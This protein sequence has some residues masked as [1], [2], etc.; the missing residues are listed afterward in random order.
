MTYSGLCKLKWH[1]ATPVVGLQTADGS[2]DPR[3]DVCWWWRAQRERER[4]FNL[5][6]QTQRF[7]SQLDADVSIYFRFIFFLSRR[8][9]VCSSFFAL[10]C[11]WL[12]SVVLEHLSV[13]ENQTADSA[14]RW[15]NTHVP[16]SCYPVRVR[17]TGPICCDLRDILV[18]FR[19]GCMRFFFVDCKCVSHRRWPS[20]PL[21]LRQHAGLDV[22]AGRVQVLHGVL[23]ILGKWPTTAKLVLNVC[24]V[25]K[26]F[27]VKQTADQHA[28]G[29]VACSLY[30]ESQNAGK[31]LEKKMKH[32]KV[33]RHF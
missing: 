17:L 14:A 11:E 4:G 21:Q 10:V 1:L 32:H 19:W 5:L 16:H 7:P 12:L 33:F 22:T 26:S 8:S 23:W 15:R 18:F 31:Y 2:L 28:A 20:G 27:C 13:A 25:E 3:E 29:G 9:L 30:F 6:P 24:I